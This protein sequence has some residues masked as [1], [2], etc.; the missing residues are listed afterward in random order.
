MAQIGH[1]EAAVRVEIVRVAARLHVAPVRVRDVAREK[2]ARDV[3]DVVAT[4]AVGRPARIIDVN[5][6][7]ARLH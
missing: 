2:G 1:G 3:L 6:E 4:V 5:A 7:A